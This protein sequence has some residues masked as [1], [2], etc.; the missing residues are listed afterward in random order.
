M[1]FAVIGMAAAVIAQQAVP[2]QPASPAQQ[3]G[4]AQQ[5]AP[6]TVLKTGQAVIV[7]RVLDVDSNTAISGAVVMLAGVS[8][9]RPVDT[10]SNGVNGSNRRIDTDPQGQFFFRD[11]PSGSYFVSASA[12]GYGTGVYGDSLLMG[13][14]DRLNFTRAVDIVETDRLVSVTIR[15]SR[16][17]GISGRVTDE[18][19]DA[20][21]GAP[22]AVFSRA[23]SPAD[24]RI[25]QT[26]SVTTDDR[27]RY[28]VDVAPGSYIVGLLTATTTWPTAAADSFI[29]AQREGGESFQ[30]YMRNVQANG[31]LLARGVGARVGQFMV[32]QFGF[33]NAWVVRP[34]IVGGGTVLF[35]PTTFHPS[36]PTVP[37]ADVIRVTSGVELEGID[38]Q[39]RPMPA[40]RVSGRVTGADGGPAAGLGLSVVATDDASL[41]TGVAV[42]EFSRALA[43]DNGDFTFLGLA[44]GTYVV[45]ATRRA[46]ASGSLEW[47]ADSFSIA[48]KDV[49]GLELR[50]KPAGAVSGRVVVDGDAIPPSAIRSMR[51][52]V[53]PVPGGFA[54]LTG[55]FPTA[56]ALDDANQF[57]I[58]PLVPG[59]H[60]ISVSQLPSGWIPKSIRT[61]SRDVLDRP[62]EIPASGL[63]DVVVTITSKLGTLTGVVRDDS[64]RS[65]PD[66][67][68]VVFSTDKSFWIL[69]SAATW[70]V[71]STA[72]MRDG[73]YTLASLPPGDYWAASSSMP[74][75]DLQDSRTLAALSRLATPVTIGEGETKSV[76]LRT[77]TVR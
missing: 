53:D 8:L 71:R 26:A 42:P 19:G 52:S 54:A 56:A 44:P 23:Q 74:G 13:Q 70:H 45:V 51:I 3:A 73:R 49:P 76:D 27:G 28:H 77:V 31:S 34:P 1:M 29:Q 10:F 18:N 72:P 58:Q 39:L 32:T 17:G 66:A 25:L 47:L 64:G 12:A 2:A 4:A 55:T 57:V 62:V 48:D 36:A 38:L 75:L 68:V 67:R 69:P 15:L 43:G 61:G 21:A 35:Y 46:A 60:R 40:L 37:T 65:V 30:A 63:N 50:M 16:L 7:G 14:R 20:V 6:P 5:S 11:L 33:Q 9:G 24:P 22:L 41:Q 59:I